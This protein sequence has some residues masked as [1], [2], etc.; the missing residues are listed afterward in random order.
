MTDSASA[1]CS[2]SALSSATAAGSSSTRSDAQ[3]RRRQP[4]L[5]RRR[6]RDRG[7]S[8]RRRGG[9]GSS[10]E[11]RR[12]RRP[13]RRARAGRV[14]RSRG[15]ELLAVLHHPVG[16]VADGRP[17]VRARGRARR[18][19]TAGREPSDDT[20]AQHGAGTHVAR[21]LDDQLGDLRRLERRVDRADDVEQARRGA[22]R[23]RAAPR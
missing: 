21:A 6:R 14:C 23:G 11:T 12:R 5:A 7:R 8:A 16:D 20:T 10:A 19:P 15:D 17:H 22:R 2:S 1:R 9:R 13:R 4:R 18:A 3:H